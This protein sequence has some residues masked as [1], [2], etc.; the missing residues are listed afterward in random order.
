MAKEGP[1]G[2]KLRLV[3]GVSNRQEG[4]KSKGKEGLFIKGGLEPP[5]GIR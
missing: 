1:G 4:K 2:A 5:R 3:E